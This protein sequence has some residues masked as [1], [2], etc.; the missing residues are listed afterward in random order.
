MFDV[1]PLSELLMF[2]LT[3]LHVKTN[4]FA[5][6]CTQT[7]RYIHVQEGSMSTYKF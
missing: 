1:F 7:F 4:S 3:Q 6:L 2:S 5:Y